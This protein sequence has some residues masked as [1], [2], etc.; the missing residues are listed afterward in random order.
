MTNYQILIDSIANE[1]YQLYN[2]SN[3]WDEIEA[4]QTS[5]NRDCFQFCS[6]DQTQFPI[7]R[8]NYTL[9]VLLAFYAGSS[10]LLLHILPI[11]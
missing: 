4:K 1:I 3:N 9:N 11:A 8:G 6:A 5:H 2:T 10:K 7:L